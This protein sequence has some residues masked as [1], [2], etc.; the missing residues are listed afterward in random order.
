MEIK[1]LLCTMNTKERECLEK[2]LNCNKKKG[3]YVKASWK[4]ELKPL[5]DYIE[6][7]EGIEKISRSVVRLGI[8]Y[9]NIKGVELS[10]NESKS[11]NW[12]ETILPNLLYKNINSGEYYIR[13]YVG[14]TKAK[15]IKFYQDKNG[16][17]IDNLDL[18]KFRKSSSNDKLECFTIKLT[19]LLSLE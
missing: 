13:L 16:N 17:V 3:Q 10:T 8:N 14:K 6:E 2:V 7:C 18:S 4:S 19:N 15:T 12:Y 1:D 9:K 11:N 5:K